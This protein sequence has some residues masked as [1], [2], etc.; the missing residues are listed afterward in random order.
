PRPYYGPQPTGIYQKI[1]DENISRLIQWITGEIP[2]FNPVPKLALPPKPA[3]KK[4]EVDSNE[5][6]ANLTQ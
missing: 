2:D 1:H 3:I 5:E 6:L 4:V